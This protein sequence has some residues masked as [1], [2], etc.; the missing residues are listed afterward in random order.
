M[1]RNMMFNV[2]LWSLL[3]GHGRGLVGGGG[4]FSFRSHRKTVRKYYMRPQTPH[5]ARSQ[6]WTPPGTP[7]N[8]HL[9]TGLHSLRVGLLVLLFW[10]LSR[11]GTVA[12]SDSCILA[13]RWLWLLFILD[14]FFFFLIQWISSC[15]FQIQCNEEKAALLSHSF[16]DLIKVRNQLFKIKQGDFMT[17]L[18]VFPGLIVLM[19]VKSP[20]NTKPGLTV[21]DRDWR[22]L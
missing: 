22:N 18:C 21:L 2:W 15:F 19:Q 7:Y 10:F 9:L 1:T 12:I 8:Q 13:L 11:S 5:Q 6:C 4:E 16:L 17:G 14:F 20:N 3:Q